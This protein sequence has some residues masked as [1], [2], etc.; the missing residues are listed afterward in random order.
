MKNRSIDHH[1]WTHCMCLTDRVY[2]QCSGWKSV[3]RLGDG[4]CFKPVWY[5][6]IRTCLTVASHCVTP[7]AMTFF[8]FL[9]GCQGA[10]LGVLTVSFVAQACALSPLIQRNR[11]R[12]R[13]LFA[14]QSSAPLCFSFLSNAT[15]SVETTL[16]PL[17]RVCEESQT[18]AQGQK[19]C[20]T[21][22]EVDVSISLA[23]AHCPVVFTEQH[24][25]PMHR[26]PAEPVGV[27]WS[28][29]GVFFL[30]L[31]SLTQTLGLQWKEL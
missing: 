10:Y 31:F 20:L 25:L 9:K 4:L 1:F 23:S 28:A 11:E 26:R 30:F 29:Y 18:L 22:C 16:K 5:G 12:S 15:I 24:L 6:R 14:A 7:Q 3:V 27:G 19:T 2:L 21:F 13:P 8:F 17:T